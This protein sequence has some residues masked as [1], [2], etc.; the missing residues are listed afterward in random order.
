MSPQ[1]ATLHTGFSKGAFLIALLLNN[2]RQ[3]GIRPPR[4]G[5]S[6]GAVQRAQCVQLVAHMQ[7]HKNFALLFCLE[8]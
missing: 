4:E 5:G 1:H 6:A 3:A 8:R 2:K 7:R